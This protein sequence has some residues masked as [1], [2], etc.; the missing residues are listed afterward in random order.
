MVEVLRRRSIEAC[1]LTIPREEDIT[2]TQL[3]KRYFM[4][5]ASKSREAQTM[6]P[7]VCKCGR[8][9]HIHCLTATVPPVHRIHPSIKILL[10]S[11]RIDDVEMRGRRITLSSTKQNLETWMLT[12]S[13]SSRSAEL[14]VRLGQI[15]L[16]LSVSSITERQPS[17]LHSTG[18]SSSLI[19]AH[20]K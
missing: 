17:G 19:S 8:V 2:R 10:K 1:G 16:C 12:A 9:L 18:R 14:P 20:R 13:L 6:G 4:T 15:P 3:S 7:V 11:R 5:L